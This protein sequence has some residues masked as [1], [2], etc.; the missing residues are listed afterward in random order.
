MMLHNVSPTYV[1]SRDVCNKV[2]NEFYKKYDT[3]YLL[4]SAVT[5]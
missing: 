1:H 4:S 3:K 5:M 2:A